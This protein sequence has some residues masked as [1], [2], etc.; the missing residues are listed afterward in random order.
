[1][2]PKAALIAAAALAFGAALLPG[3]P[4]ADSAGD[5][6]NGTLGAILDREDVLLLD[7]ATTGLTRRSVIVEIA[8]HDTTGR[9]R[10]HSRFLLPANTGLSRERRRK[11]GAKAFDDEWP[12][13]KAVLNEAGLVLAWNASF[14]NRLLNQTLGKWGIEDNWNGKI[15]DLLE[16][17]RCGIPGLAS[18]ALE[19]VAEA[20][21]IGSPGDSR[22]TASNDVG[23]LLGILRAAA[24]GDEPKTV[25]PDWAGDLPTDRQLN[26]ID[27][28][29]YELDIE[30]H[31][32]PKTKLAASRRI[33]ELKCRLEP[34]GLFFRLPSAQ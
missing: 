17:F 19:D 28:L 6:K 9:E 15:A 5:G 30:L 32:Y 26:Y 2:K 8:V 21:G 3:A 11:A 24:R 7:T 33:D 14:D 18:N 25:L 31:D 29:A 13:L 10:Y 4:V 22:D 1:M 23:V 12:A 27:Y 34:E 16:K 20:Y